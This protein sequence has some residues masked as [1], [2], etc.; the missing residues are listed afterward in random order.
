[1]LPEQKIMIKIWKKNVKNETKVHY[2]SIETNILSTRHEQHFEIHFEFKPWDG[3][4]MINI[5]S[6]ILYFGLKSRLKCN[7]TITNKVCSFRST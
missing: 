5:E 7:K 4:Q 3:C 2:L 1:M 6:L